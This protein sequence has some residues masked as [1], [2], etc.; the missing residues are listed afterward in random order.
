MKTY[1]VETH[2]WVEAE[3]EDDANEIVMEVLD[4]DGMIEDYS[5]IRTIEDQLVETPVS[6]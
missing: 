6:V 3:N 1:L 5:L 2:I 4:S